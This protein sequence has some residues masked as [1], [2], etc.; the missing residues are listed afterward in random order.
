[1]KQLIIPL[2]F[3]AITFGGLFYALHITRHRRIPHPKSKYSPFSRK[4][5]STVS[6]V[7]LAADRHMWVGVQVKNSSA[8][9][10]PTAERLMLD[11]GKKL[12]L[13]KGMLANDELDAATKL[14]NEVLDLLEQAEAKI[15]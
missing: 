13:A 4:M 10:K 15:A 12:E 14:A 2:L 6:L 5:Q 9:G 1:M 11:A 7:H 3:L 8:I